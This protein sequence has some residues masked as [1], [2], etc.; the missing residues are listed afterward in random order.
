MR[1]GNAGGSCRPR[2]CTDAIVGDAVEDDSR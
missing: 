1:K 2:D